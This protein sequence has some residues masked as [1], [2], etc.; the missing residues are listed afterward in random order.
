MNTY[1]SRKLLILCFACAMFFIGCSQKLDKYKGEI[2]MTKAP[3]DLLILGNKI[4]TDDELSPSAKTT[5]LL[6]VSSKSL[7]FFP[8][9]M[10][11][12]TVGKI[13]RNSREVLALMNVWR[14]MINSPFLIGEDETNDLH[15]RLLALLGRY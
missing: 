6:D 14:F 15:A 4:T 11:Y 3:S 7:I 10:K 1:N 13:N 5:L 9:Y 2:E 12:L 8:V